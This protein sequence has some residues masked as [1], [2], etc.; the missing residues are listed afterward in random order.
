M[1]RTIYLHKDIR[2]SFQVVHVLNMA[3]NSDKRENGYW[4]ACLNRAGKELQPLKITN[5]A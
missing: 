5:G 3:K 2:I 1:L 4:A